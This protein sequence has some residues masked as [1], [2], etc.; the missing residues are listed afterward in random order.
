MNTLKKTALLLHIF[1]SMISTPALGADTIA[2]TSPA[3]GASVSG[4][5]LAIT[6]TSSLRNGSVRLFIK[7]TEIGY[8]PTNSSGNWTFSSNEL[9]NG[10]YTITAYLSND[11]STLATT[12]NAFTVVNAESISIQTPQ[13]KETLTSNPVTISGTSSRP[14]ASVQL[15]L[16]S[17]PIGT[18]TTDSSG[19]WQTSHNVTTNGSHTI[20]AELTAS[21]KA[22]ASSTINVS[23]NIP[24]RTISG[25]VPTSGSSS[26]TEYTS[27]ADSSSV[28][29]NFSPVFATVPSV[30]ATGQSAAGTS[31]VTLT[32][33]TTSKAVLNFS[34]GTSTVHF[35]ATAAQ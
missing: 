21:G 15:S 33:V 9:A 34:P 22:V 8:T 23:I 7:N 14:S 13:D 3:N 2:I 29:V 25:S 12:Q 5:P 27:T 35:T 11:S 16:D 1:F 18:T 4:K 24:F 31:T 26:G 10:N 6:G 32:S 30:V 17:T 20:V 19:S 28:T